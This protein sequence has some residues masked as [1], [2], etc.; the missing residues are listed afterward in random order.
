VHFVRRIEEFAKHFSHLEEYP[1]AED[2]V[3]EILEQ[4]VAFLFL[5][6]PREYWHAPETGVREVV[7]YAGSRIALARGL[8][9][10]MAQ[11]KLAQLRL[12][13]PRQDKDLL[14]LLAALGATGDATSLTGHTMSIVNFPGL[15]SDLRPYVKARLAQEQRRGLRFMQHG[16][17]CA[18]VR[19]QERLELD[20]T[21]ITSLVMGPQYSPAVAAALPT[22]VGRPLAEIT[23]ALFPLPSFLP[24]LNFR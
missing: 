8:A 9:Q 13:V 21:A 20:T 2:W 7:E 17:H 23:S 16:E 15:M 3:V 4:P 10:V 19:G 18:I 11:S 22:T 1:R 5:G 6:V 14:Q 12:L 24:G